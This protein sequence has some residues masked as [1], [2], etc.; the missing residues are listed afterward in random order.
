MDLKIKGNLKGH[1]C[2]DIQEAIYPATVYLSLPWQQEQLVANAVA[3]AKETFRHVTAAEIEKRHSLQIAEATTDEEGNFEFNI[4]D[5]YRSSSFDIDFECGSV[6]HKPP[7]PPRRTPVRFHITTFHPQWIIDPETSGMHA[8]FRHQIPARWWCMIRGRY[9]DAWVISGTLRHCETKDPIPNATIK[10]F[11]ADLISDDFIGTA[12]TDAD[13]HFRID[14]TSASFRVNFIPLNLETD[15]TF[16]FFS[17]GPDVYFSA[18][19]GG[20]SLLDETRANRR[21]NVGFCLC[22]NLCTKIRVAPTTDIGESVWTGIGMQFNATFGGS[23]GFDVEGYAGSGKHALCG[24]IRLT[25]QSALQAG[26]GKAIEYRFLVSETPTPNGGPAP[27][28]ATFTK[29]VGKD[30]NLFVPSLVAKLMEKIPPFAVYDVISDA[31]DFDSEGWFDMNQSVARTQTTNGLGPLSQY[32][33]IDED[34]LLS[35]DTDA[36][37]AAADVP[38]DSVTTGS[39][40]A[41][42]SI[43]LEKIAIRFEARE[44]IDKPANLFN[45][46]PGSGKTLNSVVINNNSSLIKLGINEMDASGDC[47]PISGSIHA[48]YTVYHPHLESVLIRLRNN[49][50]S[51]NR[52]YSDLGPAG[53]VAGLAGNTNPAIDGGSNS[54]LPLNPANDLTRCTYELLLRVLRRLHNG[55]NHVDY[56]Y[57]SVLFFYET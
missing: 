24:V 49:D 1:I 13:G 51:I 18:E 50:N 57:E 2:E 54:S 16:P 30:P 6:P 31:A 9:F 11:D 41:S 32:W 35:L 45:P 8:H 29:V 22:V 47:A 43:P 55:D 23:N 42:G 39:S 19:I 5:K 53:H 37:T 33:L 4:D 46:M 17:S 10:A 7:R 15:P 12:V 48:K 27:A 52:T 34:T 14:Y 26:A 20:V 28:L 56:E 25:G 40:V 36:L 21:N 3:S 44:V 38:K